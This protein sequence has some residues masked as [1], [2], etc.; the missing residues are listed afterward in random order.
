MDEDT[1][2]FYRS[3]AQ[4]YVATTDDEDARLAKARGQ[5][6]RY[7]G[8]SMG[9]TKQKPPDRTVAGVDGGVHKKCPASRPLRP[10]IAGQSLPLPV[11]ASLDWF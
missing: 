8:N 9:F 7:T 10:A 6:S 4:A 5:G 1:I 11:W 2:R 3:H